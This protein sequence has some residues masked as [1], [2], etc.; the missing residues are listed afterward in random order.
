M[1]CLTKDHDTGYVDYAD[2]PTNP[3][4][5][6]CSLDGETWIKTDEHKQ[7]VGWGMPLGQWWTVEGRAWSLFVPEVAP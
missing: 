1:K 7:P 6:P 4:G 5:S 2:F 3:N